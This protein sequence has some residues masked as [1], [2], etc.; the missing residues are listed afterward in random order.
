MSWPGA[1]AAVSQEGCWPG[2][3]GSELDWS[4]TSWSTMGRPTWDDV[5]TDVALVEGVATDVVADVTDVSPAGLGVGSLAWRATGAASAAKRVVVA[6]AAMAGHSP[7]IDQHG[8]G[9]QHRRDARQMH[10]PRSPP[11]A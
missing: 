3:S 1:W 2:M 4:G 6:S 10:P 5:E 8:C 9:P 7:T 11:G